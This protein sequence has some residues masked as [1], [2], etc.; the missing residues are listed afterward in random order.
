MAQPTQSALVAKRAGKVK[1]GFFASAAY[2]AD[3]AIPR[4]AADVLRGHALVGRDRDTTAFLAGLAAAGLSLKR[5]DFALRTDNDVAYLA[6]MR[7]GL[8]IG[9]CQVPLAAGPPRLERVLPKLSFNLPVWVV[10]H[11]NLRA[12]RR[13]SIVF[14]HFVESL[15][16]Y[17]RSAL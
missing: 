4:S 3:H 17:V 2:L 9:I 1:L 10:T 13:V 8:G 7:A 14:E 15:A 12:S 16:R 5:K 6:A 11:E